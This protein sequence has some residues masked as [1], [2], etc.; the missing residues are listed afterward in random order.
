MS[1]FAGKLVVAGVALGTTVGAAAI[2]LACGSDLFHSTG[3]ETLCDLDA[4]ACA[5]EGG[6]VTDAGDAGDA[7]ST[8]IDLCAITDVTSAAQRACAW[9]GSCAGPLG[10]NAFGACMFQ[11]L[12]VIGCKG[13]PDMPPRG[14]ML[15]YWQCLVAA[16]NAGSCDDVRRCV[17]PAG[18]QACNNEAGTP[19]IACFNFKD[20]A[21]TRFICPAFGGQPQ[22]VESCSA[23]GRACGRTSL[24]TAFCFPK[25]LS[26]AGEG[27][28]C[29]AGCV[30]GGLHVCGPDLGTDPDIGVDCTQLGAGVCAPGGAVPACTPASDTKCAASPD[31]KCDGDIATGCPSGTVDRVNCSILGSSCSTAIAEPGHDVTRACKKSTPCAEDSCSG[32]TLTSC[33]DGVTYKA[34]CAGLGFSKCEKVNVFGSGTRAQCK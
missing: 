13:R 10:G 16:S 11:A 31:I 30:E 8:G 18:E 12:Q 24:G 15:Q 29:D 23:A 6:A 34:D 32:T 1:R 7:G 33:V 17:V 3:F 25:A 9:V 14:A 2:I 19:Y 4:Q 20:N 5:A 21:A 27:P 26:D 22:T 28:P